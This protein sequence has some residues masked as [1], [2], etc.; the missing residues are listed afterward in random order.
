MSATYILLFQCRD[1]KGIVA[2]VS[3]ALFRQGGNILTA[4]QY[5]T[6]PHDGH[7]FLRV[8]FALDG[9][10]EALP[11]LESGLAALSREFDARCSLYDKNARM[12]M[13]ILVSEPDHCLVDLLYLWRSGE[14]AV[15]IPFVVSNR[16]CHRTVTEQHGIPFVFIGASKDDRK[17]EELLSRVRGADFLV[18]ARYMLVLSSVFL[19]S[20]GRDIIN[21]HHG[22]LPSFKGP[23]P[24][25]Q[26][27]AHGVKVIGATAHFVTDNLD[28]GPIISQAVEQVSHEETVESLKRKGKNLEKRALSAAV[29]AYIDHRVITHGNTTI[30][31]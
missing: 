27:L 20:F 21:I 31:F 25:G 6:D 3:D 30:V 28:E 11:A 24:Y 13:G 8:E 9:G 29:S 22:L 18:L 16:E 2:K 14:L 12:R 1:R 23:D 10:A 5:T 4:D 26:A 19:K 17:E 7:F 15:D